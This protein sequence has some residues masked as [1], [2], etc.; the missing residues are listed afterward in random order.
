M[1]MINLSTEVKLY[2]NNEDYTKYLIEGSLSDDSAYSSNIITTKGTIVLGGDTSILDFKKTLFPIGSTVTVYV[3]RSNNKLYKLPRGH[4]YVLNSSINVNERKT[5]LE[6]GCS[7]AFLV[8]RESSFEDKIESLIN[9]TFDSDFKSSFVIEDYNLS[10]LD[11]L[12]KTDGKCIFQDKH[13]YVQTIDQFGND[14]YGANFTGAKLT[15]YDKHTAINIEALQGSI[16]DLPSSVFIEES[17]EIPGETDEDI[18]PDPFIT[19]V[20]ERTIDYIDAIVDYSW[21]ITNDNTG[22]A[23]TEA[24]PGCGTYYAPAEPEPPKYAYTVTGSARTIQKEKTE[25]VTSGSF[26]RYEGPGNQVDW[27]YDFEHCSALTYA[28]DILATV[29]NKYMQIAEEEANKAN[30]LLSKANQYYDKSDQEFNREIDATWPSGNDKSQAQIAYEQEKKDNLVE[31][32]MCL[33]TQMY[34][35]AEDILGLQ[36]IR[37]AGATAMAIKASEFV[38]NYTKIYGYSRI[39]STY[40]E[41]GEGDVLVKK[42]ELN[43][44][45]AASTNNARESANSLEAFYYPNA[46]LSGYRYQIAGGV[47]FASFRPGTFDA[48]VEGSNLRTEHNDSQFSNPEFYF[49]QVLISRTTTT[50]EYGT[51]YTTEKVLFEDLEDPS[52]SSFKTSY[53]S[54]DSANADETD[55]IELQ[56]DIN[57]CTILNGIDTEEEVLQASAVVSTGGQTVGAGWLGRPSPTTKTVTIPAQFAPIVNKDCDGSLVSVN[58]T[59]TLAKYQEILDKYVRNEAL[60]VAG[61]NFGYRITESATRAEALDYYPFYPITLALQSLGK[62]Y[63]LRAASSNFVFDSSNVLCSFDCFNVGEIRKIDGSTESSP[64]DFTDSDNIGTSTT[65]VLDAAFFNL[66]STADFITITALSSGATFAVSGSPLSVGDTVTVADI[67]AGNVTATTN[68][69]TTDIF[70]S[71]RVTKTNGDEFGDPDDLF[72]DDG[73]QQPVENPFA[74]A[75]DFD[76]GTTNGGNPADAGE[77]TTNTNGSGTHLNAGDFDTGKEV[78]PSEPLPGDGASGGNNTVDPED[79]MGVDFEDGDENAIDGGQI[80]QP[81]G[82][83]DPIL[84][85]IFEFKVNLRVNFKLDTVISP[86]A[87]FD[88]GYVAVPRGSSIDMGSVVAPNTFAMDFGTVASP[89]E[90]TFSSGVV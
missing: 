76:A 48:T 81:D 65:V 2:I 70:V 72:P 30:G 42:V 79:D 26:S 45:H 51:N 11:S 5:T 4:V 63:K 7:L 17:F 27:E 25:T 20:L 49:N 46:N 31:Y 16:E 18:K 22:E 71:Y 35:A 50:Y 68:G 78:R 15:S 54:S 39:T 75:G 88:Y 77:F 36:N 74:D 44:V 8:S 55:R 84:D 29:V 60:R 37:V 89:N 1:S 73:V 14:G 58:P 19:S 61:D 56:K 87:G 67:N 66:P 9:S 69:A 38:D 83:V 13:G 52:N 3:K 24:I 40:Y 43:Y 85:N 59:A 90:P 21:R 33:A 34:E 86:Q 10:T 6:V 82:D 80:S 47:D 62:Q 12:L 32:Y 28:K 57:G 64:Y 41:Y 23:T 53:S